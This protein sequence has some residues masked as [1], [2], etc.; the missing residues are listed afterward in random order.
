M[1]SRSFDLSDD[2]VSGPGQR[3][4]RPQESAGGASLQD[5]VERLLGI[6]GRLFTAIEHEIHDIERGLALFGGDQVDAN[7]HTLF[8]ERLIQCAE[9]LD[10]S[11]HDIGLHLE[12]RAN[13]YIA[14]Y[15]LR[16]NASV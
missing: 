16:D 8:K 14:T 9:S 11:I 12:R 13:E 4:P 3:E 7:A 2:E 1:L 10:V 6:A 5:D 15:R